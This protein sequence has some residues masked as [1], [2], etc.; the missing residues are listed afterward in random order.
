MKKP[1]E[2][3]QAEMRARW[4]RKLVNDENDRWIRECFFKPKGWWTFRAAKTA[5]ER[6]RYHESRPITAEEYA[7]IFESI[8]RRKGSPKKLGKPKRVA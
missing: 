5:L 7:H 6:R 2:S 4:R 3:K 1:L 8:A